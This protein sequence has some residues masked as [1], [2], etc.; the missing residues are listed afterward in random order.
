VRLHAL[1]RKGYRANLGA[2]AD[3]GL[4]RLEHPRGANGGAPG[5]LLCP[6]GRIIGT[7]NIRPLSNRDG[8]PDCIYVDSEGDY[9]LFQ[10]F[11]NGIPDA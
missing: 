7:D 11:V 1:V 8:D 9:R 5:L 6:D 10:T 3:T 2:T 4:I